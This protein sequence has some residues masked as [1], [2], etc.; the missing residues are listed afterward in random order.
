MILLA[1]TNI[2][3]K[4]TKK[5]TKMNIQLGSVLKAK[6]GYMDE[7]TSERIKTSTRKYMMGCVEDVVCNK[8]LLVKCLYGKKIDMS[9]FSLLYLYEKE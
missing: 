8:N 5:W 1:V 9:D 3:D 4:K 2:K 6:V 7:N